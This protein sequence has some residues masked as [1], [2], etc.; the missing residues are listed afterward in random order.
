MSRADRKNQNGKKP[1]HPG[2]F[3]HG[4]LRVKDPR[5]VSADRPGIP[6]GGDTGPVGDT[7]GW[8]YP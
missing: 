7:L 4:P 8:L 2:N 6:C 5:R 1:E 3:P